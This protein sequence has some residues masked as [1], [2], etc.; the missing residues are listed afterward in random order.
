MK[1]I[2]LNELKAKLHGRGWW[3]TNLDTA[4]AEHMLRDVVEIVNER[5]D[6]RQD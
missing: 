1:P 3:Y 4:T 6:D 5:E 2:T